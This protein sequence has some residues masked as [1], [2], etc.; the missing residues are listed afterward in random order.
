MTGAIPTLPGVITILAMGA[1]AVLHPDWPRKLCL[2]V[3]VRELRA[4]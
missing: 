4:S 3:A 2:V 1:V